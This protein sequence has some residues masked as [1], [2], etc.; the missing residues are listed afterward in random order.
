[1]QG[2]IAVTVISPSAM[3]CDGWDTPLFVLG[4]E[5]ARRRAMALTDL[6]AI[7]IQPGAGNVDTMWVERT[8]RDRLIIEPAAQAFIQIRYF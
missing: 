4:L 8:L 3:E 7:L 1:V 2:L 5:Q 6:D